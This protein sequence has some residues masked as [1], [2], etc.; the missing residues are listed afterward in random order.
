L[1][2]QVSTFVVTVTAEDNVTTRNYTIVVT[3]AGVVDVYYDIALEIQGRQGND[4]VTVTPTTGRHGDTVTLNYTLANV[5]TNN[6]LTFNRGL[7][8]VTTP[9]TGSMTYTINSAHADANR[10]IVITADFAH[11]NVAN[12]HTVTFDPSG[13]LISPAPGTI[14]N[15]AA[16]GAV[17][18]AS[19]GA[20]LAGIDWDITGAGSRLTGYDSP[21][22]IHSTGNDGYGSGTLQY[23]FVSQDGVISGSFTNGQLTELAQILLADF[24]DIYSLQKVGSYFIETMWS[25][26]PIKNPPTTGTMGSVHSNSLEVSNTDVATEFINM[27]MAQKAYQAN[28]K[29]ITTADQLLTEL[30]NIKR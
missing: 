6:S 29:V 13:N 23:L 30:M 16:P 3:K 18:F 10:R 8:A 24:P 12:Y 28:A 11:T 20:T 1:N 9:G 7:S 2:E 19:N 25:G 4:N 17:T 15:L 21:S 22:V 14:V 27:I 5:A 26:Q